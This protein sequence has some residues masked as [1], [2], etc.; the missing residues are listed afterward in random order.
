MEDKRL[1]GYPVYAEDELGMLNV[2][3]ANE[4]TGLQP[5]PPISSDEAESY[6]ELYNK[7]KQMLPVDNGFQEVRPEK[8]I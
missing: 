2:A 7:P 6:D 3:S 1:S 5:T 4:C 8:R